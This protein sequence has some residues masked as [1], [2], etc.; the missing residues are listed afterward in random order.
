MSPLCQG[1][2]TETVDGEFRVIYSHFNYL[3]LEVPVLFLSLSLY[4]VM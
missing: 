3:T 2:G 4:L 1:S